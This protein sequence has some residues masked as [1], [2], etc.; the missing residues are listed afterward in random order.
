MFAENQLCRC[1]SK[2]GDGER[3]N[4]PSSRRAE[5]SHI[6]HGRIVFGQWFLFV[7]SDIRSEIV[8]DS[9]NE[10]VMLMDWSSS[11]TIQSDSRGVKTDILSHRRCDQEASGVLTWG[12]TKTRQRKTIYDTLKG[13]RRKKTL[14]QK[15]ACFRRV[16]EGN[17]WMF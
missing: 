8:F 7:E 3:G 10:N 17:K 16:R 11:L 2:I 12:R 9:Y 13:R 6:W 15:M 14:L 4:H 1:H 5:Q